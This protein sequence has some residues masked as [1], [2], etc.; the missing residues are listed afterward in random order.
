MKDYRVRRPKQHDPFMNALKDE[1]IFDSLKSVMVFA[2]AIGASQDISREFSDSAEKIPL[3]I[4]NESQDIPFML[5]LALAKTNDVTNLREDNM[6]VVLKI[7]E[8]SAAA[9][10]EYLEG[11]IDQSNPKESIEQLLTRGEHSDLLT[12]LTSW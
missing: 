11:C 12:D 1:G 3:R 5:A 2:A 6:E 7:F 4:F 9:G 10:L 8:E